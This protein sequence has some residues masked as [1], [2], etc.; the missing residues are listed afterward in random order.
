MCQDELIVSG[1]APATATPFKVRTMSQTHCIS[2]TRSVS[3]HSPVQTQSQWGS[4]L[5]E[6]S[7]A[8]RGGVSEEAAVQHHGPA[9]QVEP[10]EH[11]QGQDDLQLCL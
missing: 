4:Y 6:G 10:E 11:G 2:L 9:Q 7:D 1:H 5:V 3:R 8:A